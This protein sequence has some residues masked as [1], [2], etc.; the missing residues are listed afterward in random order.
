MPGVTCSVLF[1]KV[2]RCAFF[3]MIRTVSD[4]VSFA[5]TLLYANGN[6]VS[7]ALIIKKGSAPGFKRLLMSA[8]DA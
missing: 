5:M 8:M 1:L 2:V 3:V 7:Y 6:V 4:P